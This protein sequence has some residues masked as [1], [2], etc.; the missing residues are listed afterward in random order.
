MKCVNALSACSI[1]KGTATSC[2][3]Y[4][5]SDGYCTGNSTTVDANCFP[6]TCDSASPTISTDEACEK[7]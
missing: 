1:Y 5:G 3:V 2:G 4:I 7:H 6:K